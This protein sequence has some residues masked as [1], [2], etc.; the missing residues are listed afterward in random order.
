MY[1][2]FLTSCTWNAHPQSISWE[3][4][5]KVNI[6]SSRTGLPHY[7]AVLFILNHLSWAYIAIM[8]HSTCQFLSSTCAY[9]SYLL[10]QLALISDVLCIAYPPSGCPFLV[11][12]LSPCPVSKKKIP[13][14]GWAR[15]DF[16]FSYR[17]TTVCL[18]RPS[19]V[20]SSSAFSL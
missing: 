13:Q 12:H 6:L 10:F 2:N 4:A 7:S 14:G 8:E 3:S 15:V 20:S 17:W 19:L 16:R 9:L 1:T 18:L 5:R 11:A